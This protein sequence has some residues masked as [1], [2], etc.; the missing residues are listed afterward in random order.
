MATLTGIIVAG[1]QS[2]RLGQDKRRLKLWGADGPLL[3]EHTLGAIAPLCDELIVVLNDPE[4]WPG[5]P[6]RLVTDVYEDAGSLGGIYAGLAAASAPWSLV[7]AGDMPLLNR[8]LLA[9][10]LAR[11]RNYDALVPRSPRPGA[12]RNKLSVDPLHAVYSRACLEPLRATLDAGQ[13]RIVEFLD[14]VRVVTVEPDELMQYD[15]DGDSFRNINTPEDLEA[16]RYKLLD[17]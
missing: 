11:P 9:A 3:L 2:R 6:A 1:G 10:L 4:Q 15:P 14:R 5:L 12:A 17:L 16:V 13:R 7:V 8:D